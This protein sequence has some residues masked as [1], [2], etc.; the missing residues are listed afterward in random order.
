MKMKKYIHI[1]TGTLISLASTVCLCGCRGSETTETHHDHEHDHSGGEQLELSQ[2]QINTVGIQLGN[3][4]LREMGEEISVNGLL[5]VGPE[6]VANVTPLISGVVRE[7]YVAEGD[8]VKTGQ[9]VAKIE[10]LDVISYRQNYNDAKIRLQM[11]RQE[12]DRQKLL[13]DNGAG[14]AKNLRNAQAEL[15]ICRNTVK[16]IENQMRMAGIP[17][18]GGIS[19]ALAAVKAPANGVV[20]KIYLHVGSMADMGSP[21]MTITDNSKIYALLKAY[22]KDIANINKGDRVFLSLTN[23]EGEL[24]GKVA[25]INHTLDP[26]SKTVDVKVSLVEKPTALLLP[27][28]AV[29]AYI[30]SSPSKVMAVPEGAIVSLSGKSYIYLLKS[31]ENEGGETM[32]HFKPVEIIQGQKQQGYV[33][34]TP[35]SELNADSKIVTAKAFYLA[36]MS[37]DHGEHNH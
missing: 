25:E 14:I 6:A 16:S 36:S 1:I 23:G 30:S 21:V 13:A 17:L 22:E 24:T 2:N 7:I 10:N 26:S 5:T 4:E 18:D 28:M 33:E 8:Y 15:E 20:N 37:A 9:T 35:L 27:G 3:L 19:S 11:A 12:Y 31:T 34:I 32:Y 29:N